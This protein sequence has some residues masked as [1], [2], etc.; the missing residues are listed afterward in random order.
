MSMLDV[1]KTLRAE[2]RLNSSGDEERLALC[3][4]LSAVVLG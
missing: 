1:F 3:N 2:N 4:T